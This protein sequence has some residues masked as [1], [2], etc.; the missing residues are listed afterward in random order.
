[1]NHHSRRSAQ[2]SR[3]FTLIELLVVIAIIAILAAIL[4]PVFQKVRENA[5]RASCQSNLKQISTALIQYTQD[6]DELYPLSCPRTVTGQWPYNYSQAV[7]S[8]WRPQS[9]PNTYAMRDSFWANSLQS[10]IK[11]YGV[12][13]CPSGVEF[14]P[15]SLVAAGLYNNPPAQPAD[16]SYA[17][18]GNLGGLNQTRIH[19]PSVLIA[20]SERDG[21]ASIVGQGG[22]Y[23][24]L[25]C[26]DATQP[27]VYQEP[28]PAPSNLCATGN[29]GMDAYYVGVIP[30][31]PMVHTRG[32]NYAY[33]D[34]HVKWLP[35][36]ND[37]R[38]DPYTTYTGD[39]P[40]Q[41]VADNCHAWLFRPEMDHVEFP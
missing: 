3:G 34:G 37:Y 8:T 14:R 29:G 39:S 10:F 22:T 13:K 32:G 41:V 9:G 21:P 2:S 35:H 19:A 15:A 31:N 27:C 20:F 5:R 24:S 26:D 36:N 1:M 11:S 38:Y 33:C 12:Y 40:T 16:V 30:I 18:N 25:K 6:S 28:P 17:M 7:P 4:F 23:P